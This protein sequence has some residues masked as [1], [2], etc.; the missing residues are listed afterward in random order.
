MKAEITD[1]AKLKITAENDYESILIRNWMQTMT[2]DN[3]EKR[4][5]VHLTDA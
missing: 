1:L 5:L 3:Y 4:I 2:K